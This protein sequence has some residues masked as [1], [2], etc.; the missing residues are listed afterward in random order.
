MTICIAPATP[1]RVFRAMRLL[2]HP[3]AWRWFAIGALIG[4][5]LVGFARFHVPGKGFTA[6]IMVGGLQSRPGLP[7]VPPSRVYVMPESYG[8]DGQWY[9]LLAVRSD[10]RDAALA[11]ALD[12]LPFRARRI[13][14]SWTAHL[15]G[16]GDPIRVLNVY[17]LQNVFCWVVLGFVLLRWFPPTDWT[18]VARWGA[19]LF[20]Y[21]MIFSVRGAL[22]DGPGLLLVAGGM[23]LWE[24]N[25]RWLAALVLGLGGL[26]KETGVLAASV[27]ADP[28]TRGGK[29]WSK[30]I[31]RGLLVALPLAL[32]SA[33][34]LVALGSI[35]TDPDV[36]TAAFAPPLT[37][38][39]HQLTTTLAELAARPPNAGPSRDSLYLLIARAVQWLFFALRPR[40]RDPWWRLGAAYAGLMLLLG[41]AVW[42]G[43][44]GAA[45][46]V[47]L[48]LLLAFNVSLPRRWGWLP[49]FLLGNLTV[50]TT[51]TLFKPVA[52]DE[53]V[54]AGPA[55]LLQNP[56]GGDKARVTFDPQWMP[57]E[58][59]FW[60]RWRWCK[61]SATVIVHNPQ[62][63]ALAATL[64]CQITSD[65]PR[66][67]TIR[68]ATQGYWTGQLGQQR[69]AVAIANLRLESG[70]TVIRFETDR[71]PHPSLNPGDSR[72]LAFRVYDLRIQFAES[73][74]GTR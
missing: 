3:D 74:P 24:T 69:T 33:W 57:P 54:L 70:D 2:K 52:I 38:Y 6:L 37:G 49:V 50:L 27:F 58:Q 20:S 8:Y 16:G 56:A 44:P 36:R 7:E 22:A 28:D 15:L 51:P 48:P 63:N 62:A 31:A 55:V 73:A 45:G 47:L 30:L 71:P 66:G 26:G 53:P 46:R 10:P 19:V 64:T 13:L 72:R 40:W 23:A 43:R 17:A 42:E 5:F 9:A 41:P 32:W 29:S 59:S 4:G 61:D 18:G 12:H 11:A 34:L 60:D 68:T 65:D 14:F 67:L 1:N 21:G 39:W 25:R 35:G